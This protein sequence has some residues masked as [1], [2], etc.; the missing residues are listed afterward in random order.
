[1]EISNVT[2]FQ[3]LK[4]ISRPWIALAAAYALALQIMLSLSIMSQAAAAP[5]DGVPT[6]YGL[7]VDAS[8]DTANDKVGGK[9]HAAPCILCSVG[10]SAPVDQP[11]ANVA[12]AHAGHG[13]VHTH[14]P[15]DIV[16]AQAPP[17]PRLSQGPPQIA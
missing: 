6:C 5:Q 15:R 3:H 1:V 12:P 13:V 4:R 8:G 11:A 2:A 17:S 14:A 9:V 10:L 7:S 16:H